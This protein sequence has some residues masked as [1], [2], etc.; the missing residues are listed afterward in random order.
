[1]RRLV[2]ALLC[3]LAIVPAAVAGPAASWRTALSPEALSRDD[4]LVSR[5]EAAYD[6]LRGGYTGRGRVPSESAVMLA[7]ADSAAGLGAE[8]GEHARFTLRAMDAQLDTHGGGYFDRSAGDDGTMFEVQK[9]TV[10]NARRLEMLIAAWRATG[11]EEYRRRAAELVRYSQNVLADPRGGFVVDEVGDRDPRPEPN[12]RMIQAWLEWAAV[13]GDP[14]LRSYAWLSLDR[15]WETSWTNGLGL[16]QVGVFGDT[17]VHAWLVDQAEMGRALVMSAR[18]GGRGIDRERAVILGELLLTRYEDQEKGGFASQI[19]PARN[20]QVKRS[21]TGIGENARAV[22]FLN[23]LARLT[24]DERYRAAAERATRRA[25][26]LIDK[27][28]VEAADW[29]LAT[30]AAWV[31]GMPVAPEW[32]VIAEDVRREPTPSKTYKTGRR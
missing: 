29:A 5:V 7:F 14:R 25:D 1:M 31:D 11:D 15:T 27:M 3:S 12:G 17:R 8:R 16:V 9:S 26:G 32:H 28:G 21:A 24:G 19:V 10:V 13:T 22:L 6:T 2:S 20:D 18:L 4:R 30:R 23:D